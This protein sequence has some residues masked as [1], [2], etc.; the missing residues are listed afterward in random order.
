MITKISSFQFFCLIVL[1]ELGSALLLE[2]GSGAGRHAWIAILMGGLLGCVLYLAYLK[3]YHYYPNLTLTELI[4]SV[5]GKY[6]GWIVALI[7]VLYFM[8]MA[9]RILRDFTDLLIITSYRNTSSAVVAAL[10]VA[11]SVYAVNQGIQ[12]IGRVALTSIGM[13]VTIFFLLHLFE[14]I[15][16]VEQIDNIRPIY[17]RDWMPIFT[18]VFPK[19]LTIPFGEMI[20]FAMLFPFVSKQRN[21]KKVGVYG[22]IVSASYLAFSSITNIM[23]LDE[24]TVAESTFPLLSAISLI[25][26]ANFITRLESLVVIMLVT[27]GLYKLIIFFYCAVQGATDL[28]KKKKMKHFIL[29]IALLILILSFA[30]APNHIEHLYIGLEIVP[31]YVHLPLQIIIPILLLVTAIIKAK[32]IVHKK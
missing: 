16:G 29:P 18:T 19:V 11:V 27:L 15:G 25:N 3:L 30:I 23:I 10:M 2:I 6:V 7:Y 21:L 28:F 24:E 1:F 5:W 17:P 13:L 14:I 32:Y 22:I 4:Q 12:T 8:Y 9:A 26:V 20:T 31:Y